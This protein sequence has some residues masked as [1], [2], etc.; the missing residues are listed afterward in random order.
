MCTSEMAITR[1]W[2]AWAISSGNNSLDIKAII[3]ALEVESDGRVREWLYK[4]IAIRAGK[5]ATGVL[6]EG[7]QQEEDLLILDGII[8]NLIRFHCE[9]ISE[10]R[11]IRNWLTNYLVYSK[12]DQPESW[13]VLRQALSIFYI[14][15]PSVDEIRLLIEFSYVSNNETKFAICSLLQSLFQ[16]PHYLAKNDLLSQV[17]RVMGDNIGIVKEIEK[18][19]KIIIDSMPMQ[20]SERLTQSTQGYDLSYIDQR[21]F[22]SMSSNN[23]LTICQ[24]ISSSSVVDGD[25]HQSILI[26]GSN[27]L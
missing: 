17:G 16:Q 14:L 27:D 24:E 21:V 15:L 13:I 8:E 12:F 10:L 18:Q 5:T 25:I 2:S 26:E 11:V 1:E 9:P 20:W 6:I 23:C 7:F 19:Q 3:T 22:V 4:A